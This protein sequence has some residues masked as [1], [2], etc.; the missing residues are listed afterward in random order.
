MSRLL[1]HVGKLE[2]LLRGTGGNKVER[3]LDAFAQVHWGEV[4][5]QVRAFNPAPGAF[6]EVGGE[7]VR[8]N[9]AEI[10]A[11]NGT[12]GMVH[13][14]QL[15][16]ACGEGAIR[17]RLVQRAGRGVMTS[18]ELLRGFALPMGTPL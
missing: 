9:A 3:P 7:R 8:V 16:I 12:P 15:T 18:A 11:A 5:R 17:P 13:D 1:D 14:D 6:F 2:P 4:E 10:V